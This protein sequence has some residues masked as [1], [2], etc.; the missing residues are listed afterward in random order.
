MKLRDV[1]DLAWRET[2]LSP[3]PRQIPIEPIR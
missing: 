3:R 2:P 1:G